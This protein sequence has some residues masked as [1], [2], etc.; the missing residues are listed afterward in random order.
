L[1]FFLEKDAQIAARFC[2]LD[3][4]EV[5]GA[6][7][8]MIAT[9]EIRL[10]ISFKRIAGISLPGCLLGGDKNVGDSRMKMKSVLCFCLAMTIQP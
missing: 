7:V 5:E 6:F 3:D 9:L 2:W 4:A 10:H 1:R 8:Y